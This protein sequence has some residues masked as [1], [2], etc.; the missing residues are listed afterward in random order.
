[1][2]VKIKGYDQLVRVTTFAPQADVGNTAGAQTIQSIPDTSSSLNN[3]YFYLY[4]A[5]DATTYIVWINVGGAGTAPS[6]PFTTNASVAIAVDAT[7]NDVA[8]ALYTTINGLADFSVV[9]PSGASDTITITN[10]ANGGF[11]VAGDGAS[12]NPSNFV[13]NV[14]IDGEVTT[15]G[16]AQNEWYNIVGTTSRHK[17]YWHENSYVDGPSPE[18]YPIDVIIN[19]DHIEYFLTN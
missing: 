11:S 15:T 3:T 16:F 8:D 10:A 9:D 4:S 18:R 14:T 5:Q 19:K 12:I 6:I 13:F 17:T 7:A 1:M 2:R